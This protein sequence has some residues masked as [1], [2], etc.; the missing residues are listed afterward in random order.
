MVQHSYAPM[1]IGEREEEAEGSDDQMDELRGTRKP[2]KDERSTHRREQGMQ[3]WKALPS[4]RHAKRES[5]N[6][7]D[8]AKN[9]K[10]KKGRTLVCYNC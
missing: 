2:R 4:G 8:N 10:N 3:P 9:Q 5:D 1:D 6:G 7:Q